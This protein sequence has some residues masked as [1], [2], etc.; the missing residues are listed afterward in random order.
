MAGLGREP[1]PHSIGVSGVA[2]GNAAASCARIARCVREWTRPSKSTDCSIRLSRGARPVAS[3]SGARRQL[4]RAAREG[5]NACRGQRGSGA[6]RPGRT[7]Q[8]VKAS[9]VARR[10]RKKVLWTQ[11]ACAP[12]SYSSRAR[13]ARRRSNVHEVHNPIV[14]GQKLLSERS[15]GRTHK[16]RIFGQNLNVNSLGR[17]SRHFGMPPTAPIAPILRDG[18]S[19]R[20]PGGAQK[21]T[22]RDPL[23]LPSATRRVTKRSAPPQR[24]LTSPET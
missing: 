9:R 22:R 19:P 15:T 13:G 18:G 4:S 8:S 24:R 12:V 1:R 7:T 11:A 6:T 17:E 3:A 21:K 2:R 23:S 5:E 14:K 20:T 10:L 16:R